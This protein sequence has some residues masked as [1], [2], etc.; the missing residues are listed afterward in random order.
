M[1][2]N[3]RLNKLVILLLVLCFAMAALLCVSGITV[4]ATEEEGTLSLNL[5]GDSTV[6]LKLGSEYKEYGAYAYDSVKGDISEDIVIDNRV[7]NNSEGSYKVYYTVSNG[8]ESVQKERTVVVFRSVQ[9]EKLYTSVYSSSSSYNT[10]MRILYLADNSI[11]MYGQSYYS[12]VRLYFVKYD[13]DMNK[14]WEKSHDLYYDDDY[15]VDCVELSDGNFLALSYNNNYGYRYATI[16]SGEDGSK[17]N[18]YKIN[19]YKYNKIVKASED[20]YYIFADGRQDYLIATY[21]A[22]SKALTTKE[23]SANFNIYN[24]LV[25]NGCLY[26]FNSSGKIYKMDLETKETDSFD[27]GLSLSTCVEYVYGDHIYFCNGSTVYKMD[28]EFNIVSSYTYSSSGIQDIYINDKCVVAKFGQNIVFL[29]RDLEY[30]GET[31][32]QYSFS[33]NDLYLDD[34]GNLYYCGRCSSSCALVKISDIAFFSG[35]TDI[36][37]QINQPVDY[38]TGVGLIDPMGNSL[39]S[40]T[41][42]YSQVDTTRAGNYKAYYTFTTINADGI[43]TYQVSR[44]VEVSHVTTFE[45]GGVYAGSKVVDVEG[46]SVTINGV[47]YSYGDVFNIPGKS[48]MVIT[49]EN[50]TKTISFT[51]ELTVEGVENDTTYY[52]TLYPVISGGSMTLNGAEYNGEPIENCG[53][54]TLVIS[55]AGGYK[56]TLV[57]V[58]ET[59]VTGLTNGETYDEKIT[60]SFTKGTA[61]LNGEPYVSGTTVY[62]PGLNT[63]KIMGEKGYSV[64]YTFTVILKTENITSGE[65]YTGEVTPIISGGNIT[66]NNKPYVSGTKIDIPGYYTITVVGAGGF[67]QEF[68]FIVKPYEVNVAHGAT[69]GHSVVPAVSGGNLTLNGQP[70]ISGS[71]INASGNYTLVIIGENGYY[72]SISFTLSAGASVE[73]GAVY[74]QSVRLNFVGTAT[75]NGEEVLTDTVIEKV[76]SYQ[77]ILTDGESVTTYN[78]TVEPDYSVFDGRPT[79]CVIDFT[80]C[81]VTLNGESV[82]LPVTVD[83]VGDYVLTVEG[84]G[85]YSESVSFSVYAE[86]SVENGG[87]YPIGTA[88]NAAGGT[89][90]LNGEELAD[91]ISLSQV[92]IYTLVIK[93]ENGHEETIVFSIVPEIG[94]LEDTAVYYGSVTPTVNG[95]TLTL[96]GEAYVSGKAITEAGVYQLVISGVGGYEETFDFVLLPDDFEIREYGEYMQALGIS[97]NVCDMELNG[98]PYASGT[99]IDA[100][101]ENTLSL[102]YNG[103]RT[104]IVFYILPEIGGVENC[105]IYSGA[106]TPDIAWNALL[107]DGKPYVSGTEISLV[108]YHVITVANL[109]GYEHEIGFT[110]T[111][112]LKNIEQDGVYE[113]SVTPEVSNCTLYLDGAR[114]TSGNTVYQVGYHTLRIVGVNGYE[115]E[116]DFTVTERV[117]GLEN[118][119]EYTGSVYPSISNADLYVNGSS[120][121]SGGQIYSV[122]YYTLTVSGSNGYVS[123]YR[124]TILPNIKGAQPDGEY[125]PGHTYVSCDYTTSI[126]L[127]GESWS[128]GSYVYNVGY[129]TVEITGINGYTYSYDFTV[130]PSYSGVSD[131]SEV[132]GYVNFYCDYATLKLNGNSYS[133]G[134]YI[135]DLGYH[136]MEI[137]GVNGYTKTVTF[138]RKERTS[139]SDG[140]TV[141]YSKSVSIDYISSFNNTVV[142]LDG[143]VITDSRTVYDIGYHTLRFEGVNGYVS[144]ITF[145]VIANW[146]GVTDGY[147]YTAKSGTRLLLRNSS[148]SGL[149]VDY[150]EKILLD[151]KEYVNGTYCYTVGNHRF[152]IFGSNGYVK[153]VEFTI[154]HVIENF[155]D[156]STLNIKNDG[157]YPFDL[158]EGIYS[159]TNKSN[160]SRAVFTATAMIDLEITFQYYVSSEAN[161]DRL[162]VKKNGTEILNKSGL[163]DWN[164]MDISLNKGDILEISYSKD[165]SSAS[166]EDCAKFSFGSMSEGYGKKLQPIIYLNN[167]SAYQDE[168]TYVL[169]DG[170]PYALNS[171][172]DEIGYHTLKIVGIGGYE[173]EYKLTVVPDVLFLEDDAEYAGLVTPIIDRSE[174][175]L[176]GEAHVNGTVIDEVGKHTLEV[177]GTNGYVLRFEFTVTPLNVANYNGKVF[178]GSVA[179]N[180]IPNATLYLNGKVYGGEVITALGYH[181]LNIVGSG[182][183]EQEI[184]FTVKEDSSLIPK[185]IYNGVF[186]LNY[187]KA[188][189]T[190]YVDNSKYSPNGEYYTVGYHTMRIVGVNGYEAEYPFTVTEKIPHL[191]DGKN[192][193]T[194]IIDCNYAGAMKLNGT[195]IKDDHTVNKVG[196]Y[197]LTVY[198]TNGYISEYYFTISLDLTGVTDRGEY[199]STVVLGVN[200][201]NVTLNGSQY[202]V[203][204]PVS[205]VG[206]YTVVIRGEGG[207]TRTVYFKISPVI[208]GVE[209]GKFYS[210]AVRPIISAGQL[211]LNGAAYQSGTPISAVGN[212]VIKIIGAKNYEKT[213]SFTVLDTVSGVADGGK[214][215]ESVTP[216]FSSGTATL[217]GEKFISGTTVPLDNVGNHRL[218][219]V[220]IGGYE[221][222]YVF[223]ILPVINGLTEGEVYQGGVAPVISGGEVK[224]NGQAVSLSTPITTVGNNT[225]T[226]YGTNGYVKQIRFV[227]EPVI[228]GLKESYIQ[229]YI[230]T[231]LGS[232]FTMTLNGAEFEYGAAV[233]TVGNNR[234][235]I[236]GY[237]GYTKAYTI[238]VIP[239]IKGIEDG[240]TVFGKVMIGVSPDA[241]LTVDG[242]KYVNNSQ[243]TRVGNHTLKVVG[244]NGFEQEYDFILREDSSTISVGQYVG[245][246]TLTYDSDDFTVLINGSKYASGGNYYTVGKHQVQIVGA[247][248]YTSDYGITV[249]PVL[250]ISNMGKYNG[251]VKITTN[252]GGFY[253][254]GILYTTG[255]TYNSVGNHTL[256]MSGNGGYTYS[257]EFTVTPIITGI[258]DGETYDTYVTWDISSDCDVK[259]DC[260]SVNPHSSTQKVGDHTL[261]VEGV[262]GYQKTLKFT[263]KEKINVIDGGKYTKAITISV[264]NCTA[265]LNDVK[266]SGSYEVNAPGSYTLSIIGTNGYT[267]EYSFT[268]TPVVTGVENGKEYTNS[269]VVNTSVGQWYL[270][271]EPYVSGTVISE[272]GYHTLRVSGPG[273]EQVRKFTI[274]VD[275]S[276]YA[277]ELKRYNYVDTDIELYLDGEKYVSGTKFSQVGNHTVEYRGVNG[278]VS[279]ATYTIEYS[280]NGNIDYTYQNSAVIDI[281]NATLYLNGTMIPNLTEIT[282]IGNNLITVEGA[283]GYKKEFTILIEPSLAVSNGEVISEKVTIDKLDADMTLDGVTIGADT[284]VAKHGTHV[285]KIVG[286][287]GYVQE[288]S[289]TYENPNYSYVFLIFGVIGVVGLAMGIL[290]ITRRKVL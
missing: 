49:G 180:T 73:D 253:I 52:T 273:Y 256:S 264:P 99:L 270:D 236:N 139:V 103:K 182:G 38:Y 171:T 192:Y 216:V 286:A 105:G 125:Y 94:S 101:G 9:N 83:K 22:Q 40:F 276:P 247:N 96:N 41:C 5:I 87:E 189:L 42:D 193:T 28:E 142:K 23:M 44:N 56:E 164:S 84:E 114:F 154:N 229:S 190:V 212:H 173:K 170:E 166:G 66:L 222:T 50:Y 280:Y 31:Y 269:V 217:D 79:S 80:N 57:F 281:P 259:L 262:N 97:G 85:G 78:F 36:H 211:T 122:G 278:Y 128:S 150:Y 19:S 242:E 6:Y 117:Y 21:D 3:K 26:S 109:N 204:T 17:L 227:I 120:F 61:T 108:G 258:A 239:V 86:V 47:S 51:V 130:I 277:Y 107:L 68:H 228:E 30:I 147:A 260:V 161:Y 194:L 11:L 100:L 1:S 169:L 106:V 32:T 245:A 144:E 244:V 146:S 220:G 168:E 88:V 112:V 175:L 121:S 143:E 284:V 191:E 165:G 160:S 282:A 238:T 53:N 132:T 226:I 102:V 155:F 167:T 179:V 7:D 124:F 138:T 90:T 197:L 274:V 71:V 251:S 10:Y 115:K 185:D 218:T 72:E 196:N 153:T 63:L 133:S 69:Y 59:A 225:L 234:L 89:A 24:A 75:L 48:T 140:E 263:V 12:G 187:A 214:Y 289:F 152:E 67:K 203:G 249:I 58:I 54:Y 91:G 176:D 81:T 267:N 116:I 261:T 4:F 16:I 20:A 195:L 126:K 285:L 158:T 199:N 46:A 235:E 149:S 210:S 221:K 266:I 255:C 113:Y 136:E 288:I 13:A 248:G 127:N 172:I 243:Y 74:N 135:Y 29:N 205:D 134:N 35:M 184:S 207:Y 268:V 141:S 93:G 110:V 145:T 25:L 231:V 62:T 275:V 279:S 34:K 287:N 200:S 118:G 283:G 162:I 178:Y 233:D 254:D 206:N 151:G 174:L 290:F 111:E 76:G 215:V 129:Y 240:S 123:E 224:L 201:D 188:D 265:Y 271:D 77:L 70:Y 45:E 272:I 183:Y 60:P 186:V 92:G 213:I 33:A 181:K 148:G 208:S 219:I 157:N 14:V 198:G 237:G 163:V 98:V 252:N 37:T 241:L 43:K 246:F 250:N 137:I 65:T 15:S 257:L 156:E 119:K 64:T 55:G 177:L 39:G 2:M 202:V 82:T 95:G 18:N 223:T 27:S 232:G 209:D 230:P 131:G 104:D 8:S 159:S